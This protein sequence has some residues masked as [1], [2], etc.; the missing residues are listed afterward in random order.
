MIKPEISTVK[1]SERG[2]VRAFAGRVYVAV[3]AS[4]VP[5]AHRSVP[6]A[7]D[8]QVYSILQL[9]SDAV[10]EAWKEVGAK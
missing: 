7:G 8:S 3:L 6:E 9:A 10:N 5:I 4:K 1:A 2:V